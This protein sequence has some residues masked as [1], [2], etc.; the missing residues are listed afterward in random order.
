MHGPLTM[1]PGLSD[2]IVKLV[3]V[4]VDLDSIA[5]WVA[6]FVGKVMKVVRIHLFAMGEKD[7]MSF[8]FH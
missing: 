3:V 8:F 2:E 6:N 4:D 1:S 7:D 5:A